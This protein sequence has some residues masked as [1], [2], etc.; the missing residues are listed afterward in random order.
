[1][2]T[3]LPYLFFTLSLLFMVG[4]GAQKKTAQSAHSVE[5]EKAVPA[6]HTCLISGAH[7]VVTTDENKISATVTMQTV[8]DSMLIIS[9]MPML[10]IEMLRLE[11]TPTELVA[12][13]KIHGQYAQTTYTELN[14]KL[15]PQLNW[16]ILQQICSA[17]LPTGSEQARLNYSF[18]DREIQLQLTYPGRK[19]DVPVRMQKQRLAKYTQI[20]I[21]K[22]L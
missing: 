7:A 10:G 8:R 21:T 2:K 17:E 3:I 4:C 11:A 19:T 1:M 12:I 15:T 22:W 5:E 13:D 16:D 18:G 9:V 20:D 6:W 14:R